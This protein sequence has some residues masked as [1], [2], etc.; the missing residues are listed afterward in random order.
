MYVHISVLTVFKQTDNIKSRRANI[1]RRELP[2]NQLA[3]AKIITS[4]Q[5]K[6]KNRKKINKANLSS[7]AGAG[8]VFLRVIPR[9]TSL[10]RES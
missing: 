10:L 1:Y 7:A 4:R 8:A 9:N 3:T 2:K 5:K 6:S